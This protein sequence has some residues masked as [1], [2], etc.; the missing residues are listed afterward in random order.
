MHIHAEFS[1]EC[2]T[3]MEVDLSETEGEIYFMGYLMLLF[4]TLKKN[5][6]MCKQKKFFSSLKTFFGEPFSI[7]FLFFKKKKD[8]DSFTHR[9]PFLFFW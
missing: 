2:E 7:F 4:N 9:Q 6:Y 5:F 8:F 3:C 1:E